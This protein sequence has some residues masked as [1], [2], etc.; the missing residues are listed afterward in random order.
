MTKKLLNITIIPQTEKRVLEKIYLFMQKNEGFMHIVSL[1]PENIV[2]AQKNLTFQNVLNN[3]EIQI[4]DGIGVLLGCAI[5]NIDSG[6]RL[7]GVDM[8]KTILNIANNMP[9]RV[10]FIGGQP[11]LAKNIAECY[12][13][14]FPNSQ[15]IGSAGFKDIHSPT[16]HEKTQVFSI[17]STLKPHIIFAAF[18]S[19]AQE[20]WLEENKGLFQGAIGMGVGG[21]FDFESGTVP[22]APL[23]IRNLGFEWLYRLIKQPWRW[24]RQHNLLTF[25]YLILKQ[26]FSKVY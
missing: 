3:A 1:N 18:G 7:P 2:I 5:L 19:P 4:I 14:K 15:F 6:D 25:L 9:L 10:L 26:R 23:L 13:K 22:R 20:L 24:K 11:N 8:M 16:D 12:S 21:A 17:V